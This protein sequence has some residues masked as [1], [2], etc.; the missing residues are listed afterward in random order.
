MKSLIINGGH[1]VMVA[2]AF[3]TVWW[4]SIQPRF[5]R[6]FWPVVLIGSA[7]MAAVLFLVTEPP[8]P[9]EDFRRAYWEAG[10]TAWKG[11]AGFGALYARGTD[12]FVNL[13]IVAW[14]FAPFAPFA[15]FDAALIFTALGIAAAVVGWLQL[16]RLLELDRLEKA[17]LLIVIA[18]FGPMLYSLREGIISHF[19]FAVMVLAMLDL[20]SGREIRAGILFG[21]T[22]LLKPP[23]VLFGVY[24]LLRR[25]WRL[26]WSGAATLA[27]LGLA[28]LAIYG[29]DLH[30]LWYETVIAPFAAGPTPAF[31]VQSIPAF[32]LRQELGVSS[33]LDWMPHAV[34]R[35]G[36]IAIALSTA[37]LAVLCLWA[38]ARQGA[39]K[40]VPESDT[41]EIEIMMVV[42]FACLV[43]SLTWSHY[44]V[45]LLPAYAMAWKWGR[46][47]WRLFAGAA[48][49]LSMFAEFM[50]WRMASG[51]FGPLSNLL[52]SHLMIGGL[53]LMA[54]LIALRIRA[55]GRPS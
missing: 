54:C 10:V 42:G 2:V 16:S 38:A 6:L 26:V 40:R 24:F 1:I 49:G 31:N 48:F 36:R 45:W 30:L 35:A 34:S 12:G 39:W 53:M 50:S 13:P 21:L 7:L 29:W 23:L 3:L 28:S 43:S 15:E 22:A 51:G 37:A 25:R 20:K 9:F 11:P 14:L 46:G 32:V 33:Y 27:G 19:L 52:T 8:Q 17:L 18:A 44:Y 41:V 5:S 47:A 55:E 4:L